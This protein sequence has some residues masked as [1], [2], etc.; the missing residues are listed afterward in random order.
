MFR[1]SFLEYLS[2]LVEA[3]CS[4]AQ[5]VMMNLPLLFHQSKTNGCT[6]IPYGEHMLSWYYIRV[7]SVLVVAVFVMHGP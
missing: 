2:K 6:L 5:F 1:K 3:N 7:L 4:A